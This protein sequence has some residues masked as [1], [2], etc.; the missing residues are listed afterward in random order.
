MARSRFI[1]FHT[2]FF[3][4]II[5]TECTQFTFTELRFGKYPSLGLR[6]QQFQQRHT[7]AGWFGGGTGSAHSPWCVLGGLLRDAMNSTDDDQLRSTRPYLEHG[8]GDGEIFR[9]YDRSDGRTCTHTQTDERFGAEHVGQVLVMLWYA[10]MCVCVH[11]WMCVFVKK[12]QCGRNCALFQHQKYLTWDGC[13]LVSRTVLVNC[14][15]Y[16]ILYVFIHTKIPRRRHWSTKAM[17]IVSDRSPRSRVFVRGCVCV[18]VS[19]PCRGRGRIVASLWSDANATMRLF[20][21]R[22]TDSDSW[23]MLEARTPMHTTRRQNKPRVCGCVGV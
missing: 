13:R 14:L 16:A 7:V 5:S 8:H 22:D 23:A 12:K 15:R 17:C 6:C 3:S 18:R 21:V 2:R 20:W 19:M 10:V 4:E 1:H 9:K 11:V